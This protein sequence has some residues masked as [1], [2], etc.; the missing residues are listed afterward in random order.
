MEIAIASFEFEKA[1]IYEDEERK[2]RLNL[3]RLSEELK[4]TPQSNVVTPEDI[5]E[6]VAGRAGVPVS[7]VKSVQVK[8]LEQLELIAKEL[9]AQ[10]PLG[11]RQW[12]EGLATYL[13]GCSA[14][15]AEKLIQAIRTA[16]AKIDP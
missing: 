3:Q 4:Q 10:I 6:A 8:E 11:S 1:R 15:E 7:V 13:A 9:T 5:M 2:E 12:T 16:K 14:A